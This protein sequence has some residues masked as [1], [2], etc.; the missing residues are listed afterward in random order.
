MRAV[1]ST[2]EMCG[3]LKRE[4]GGFLDS[5][6]TVSL[7]VNPSKFFDL[8]FYFNIMLHLVVVSAILIVG[9]LSNPP[10]GS[11]DSLIFVA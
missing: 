1:K 10:I 9:G 3:K 11:H 6:F 4:A 8:V 7:E 2:I 5:W